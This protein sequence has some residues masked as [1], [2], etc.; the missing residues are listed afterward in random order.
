[1]FRQIDTGFFT[2]DM[3]HGIYREYVILLSKR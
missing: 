3:E 1:M 2:L